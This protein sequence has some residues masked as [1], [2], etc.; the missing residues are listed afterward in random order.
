M[1]SR[2]LKNNMSKKGD[3][4]NQA[5]EQILHPADMESRGFYIHLQPHLYIQTTE[6]NYDFSR[7]PDRRIRRYHPVQ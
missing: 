1:L 4:H 7:W 5:K 6:E 3:F 2:C